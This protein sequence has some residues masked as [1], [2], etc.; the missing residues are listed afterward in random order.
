MLSEGRAIPRNPA[1]ARRESL[2]TLQHTVSRALPR[3]RLPRRASLHRSVI[4]WHRGVAVLALA[5]ALTLLVETHPAALNAR[6]MGVNAHA[7]VTVIARSVEIRLQPSTAWTAVL[8]RARAGVTGLAAEV[9]ARLPSLA[10]TVRSS[11]STSP[12]TSPTSRRL[13]VANTGGMGVNLRTSPGVG[14]NVLRAL[15]DGTVLV[16]TGAVAQA[17]GRQWLQ[18]RDSKN[19]VGW[20]VAAYVVAR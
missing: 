14:R 4:R 6:E 20:V 16:P 7:V 5:G 1:A 13:V 10:P 9:K 19:E 17:A 2:A 15:P 11:P 18:V 12:P 3:P 8:G